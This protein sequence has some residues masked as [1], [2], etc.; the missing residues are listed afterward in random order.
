MLFPPSG[1]R[2]FLKRSL[3]AT[4]ALGGGGLAWAHELLAAVRPARRL[5]LYHLH[6]GE[7]LT[8]TFRDPRGNHIPSALAEINRLLRCHHTGEIHPIDP[9]TIDY[10]SL[11]DSK[12]GGGNEFH[13]ISGYRS[14]AYNRR[15][16]RE[17]RQ[18]APRSLHLTGRAI[19]VRLPKI[20]AATLRRAAL[21][22]KLGGVGY[23]PRSG[24]VH[25]DS[26]PFRSW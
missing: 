5:A 12:L 24:F 15:L 13:I 2:S 20:G 3:L 19:D 21:D 26:G 8:I 1:R 25:L 14:P 7:R 18:V 23:Y 4:V 17:G 11:V 9:E 22:L 6:T 10:L 16:L